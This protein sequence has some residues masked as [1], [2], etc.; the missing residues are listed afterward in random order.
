MCDDDYKSAICSPSV[1]LSLAG[2]TL[3]PLGAGEEDGL[4]REWL[5]WN[6]QG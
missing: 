1:C 6:E 2:F 3:V 5:V 4:A